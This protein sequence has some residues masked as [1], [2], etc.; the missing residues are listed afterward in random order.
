MN[1][2]GKTAFGEVRY[3]FKAALQPESPENGFA[4]VSVYSDPD[5]D[6]LESSCHTLW[7]CEYTGDNSLQVVSIKDI[8][9]VVAMVPHPIP[10]DI[11][12]ANKLRGR[13]YVGEQMGLDVISM[14]GIVDDPNVEVD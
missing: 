1:L 8:E 14:A 2:Q 5:A 3:Y 12:L 10:A 6:L 7:S 4:M 9:S 13:V 11:A